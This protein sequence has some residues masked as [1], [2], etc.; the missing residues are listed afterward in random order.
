MLRPICLLFLTVLLASRAPAA[1]PTPLRIVT[2]NVEILTAPRVRAGQLQKYR[3][4]YARKE[5]LN[6]TADIIEVLNPD[7]L[8][9]VEATSKEAVEQLVERLHAKGMTDYHG[10][11]I[12][13]HDGFTG[14]DVGLITK[15]EPDLIEG[16]PIRTYYSKTDDPTYR[17]A[18]SMPGRNGETRNYT[19]SL[20]RNSGYFITIAGH[21][22][23]FLGLHLKSNPSDDYANHVRTAESKVAV[24]VINGEI[25][26]RGYLPVVLGDLNDYDPDIKDRDDSRDTATDVLRRLKDLDPER[27]G[28][29]LLNVAEFIRNQSDRY[30]SH[31]DW[32]ENGALDPADVRTMIDHI[33]L[34]VELRPYVQR[35]FIAHVVSLDTSDHFPVVVDLLLPAKE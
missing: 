32:N 16:Q 6:R 26:K 29:E 8:N 23:G 7:I 13:S 34:P 19:A 33:L 11:H 15:I 3:F 31:W 12:E 10:Y 20:S 21:K 30:S 17:Q 22:L 28:D 24:R 9:L 18:Y 5:H 27:E 35:A 1:E 14:M 2:F 4:D 25:V